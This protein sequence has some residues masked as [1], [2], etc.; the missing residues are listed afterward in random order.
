MVPGFRKG[1][2]FEFPQS[3]RVLQLLD[4]QPRR[5][6]TGQVP[7]TLLQSATRCCFGARSPMDEC[8]NVSRVGLCREGYGASLHLGISPVFRGE[9]SEQL[10]SQEAVLTRG[11]H[12]FLCLSV[13]IDL[14]LSLLARVNYFCAGAPCQWLLM[15]SS[16]GTLQQPL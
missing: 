3:P 1:N 7:R 16:L 9:G 14:W 10:C 13:I 2:E 11:L 4:S 15:V 6:E 12:L 8:D 5:M